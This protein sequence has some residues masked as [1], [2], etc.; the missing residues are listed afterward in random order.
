MSS[1]QGHSSYLD[2][3]WAAGVGCTERPFGFSA[4]ALTE[5]QRFSLE[6]G[7]IPTQLPSLLW[8]LEL[9]REGVNHPRKLNEEIETVPVRLGLEG[10]D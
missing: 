2:A 4:P 7:L 9:T 1:E 10:G 8:W 5:G 6:L 3:E